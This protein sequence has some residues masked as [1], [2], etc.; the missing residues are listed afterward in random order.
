MDAVEDMK[1]VVEIAPCALIAL[2]RGGGGGGG[3]PPKWLRVFKKKYFGGGGG[4]GKRTPLGPSIRPFP[5]V[6]VY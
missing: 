3:G 6:S 5:T 2:L 4:G 1:K